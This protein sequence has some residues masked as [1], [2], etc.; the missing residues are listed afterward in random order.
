MQAT[1]TGKCQLLSFRGVTYSFQVHLSAKCSTEANM[2]SAS[3]IM[4]VDMK[5]LQEEPMVSDS[6]AAESGPSSTSADFQR[7]S[8]TPPT[9]PPLQTQSG[10]PH[11]NY[12]LPKQSR[13]NLP[14]PPAPVPSML[15]NPNPD[16]IHHVVLIVHDHLVTVINLFGI[17]CDYLEWPSVD[18]VIRMTS[19]HPPK[20]RL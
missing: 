3:G 20:T 11:R 4:D 8:E 13:D 19:A 12:R 5:E 6:S 1:I 2:G 7:A 14:E 15:S 9:P 16:P 18:P 17:W 10:C